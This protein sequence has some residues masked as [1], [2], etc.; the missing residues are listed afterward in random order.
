MRVPDRDLRNARTHVLVR[1]HAHVHPKL[2]PEAIINIMSHPTAAPATLP[3]LRAGLQDFV[4]V[5]D[6]ELL[7]AM[8]KETM[9]FVEAIIKED[10]SLLDFIDAPFTFETSSSPRRLI[11]SMSTIETRPAARPARST[12]IQSRR[13]VSRPEVR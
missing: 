4:L 1:T 9:M 5:S 12:T 10:R 3:V 11:A 8:R 2:N 6:D 7:D 13:R